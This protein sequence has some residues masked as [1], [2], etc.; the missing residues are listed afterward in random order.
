MMA[1]Q[2]MRFDTNFWY[3]DKVLAAGRQT[4]GVLYAM[5]LCLAYR[6]D[7]TDGVLTWEQAL[8]VPYEPADDIPELLDR[9]IDV[10]LCARS[11]VSRGRRARDIRIVAWSE[12]SVSQGGDKGL[13]S[14]AQ[15]SRKYRAKQRQGVDNEPLPLETKGESVA[16]DV[17]RDI[18]G[19]ALERKK[20]REKERESAHARARARD[21]LPEDQNPEEHAPQPEPSEPE[22]PVAERLFAAWGWR[23]DADECDQLAEWAR[24]R[25]IPDD[26]LLACAAVC[27]WPSD[28][29]SELRD[30][31]PRVVP[32]FT[33][34]PDAD[35]QARADAD[36]ERNDPSMREKVA[37]VIALTRNRLTESPDDIAAK[38][39]AARAEL[40]A[41]PDDESEPW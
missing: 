18:A 5:L 38:Q 19:D 22:R 12:W 11:E 8:D 1:R 39:A 33:Y 41:I 7:A 27:P 24:M 40:A 37:D 20:E 28:V 17:A 10:G 14:S 15:R 21:P 23:V 2:W 13:T 35:N 31:E 30:Y 36:A 9:L 34:D 4:G 3:D 26:D 25:R 29:R 16:R 32:A 6:V